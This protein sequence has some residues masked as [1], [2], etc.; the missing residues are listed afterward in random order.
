MRI[1][2]VE[3]DP[4]LLDGLREGLKLGG[5]VADGVTTAADASEALAT[6]NFD[7]VVLDRMLP[8]GSGLDVLNGIRRAGNRVPVL[9]LTAKDEVGDR[10]DGLDA[11]ADDYLGKPFDL[12]EVAARLRAI[13]RRA[14]G[15]ASAQ[16]SLRG[17]TLDPASMQVLREGSAIILSRREFSILHALMANPQAIHSK[18]ALEE[19]LYGWQ[20]D[21]ESNTIEVHVHKLRA[22]L[23]SA[24]I[25][26]VRGVGYRL[27][28]P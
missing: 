2:I 4:I 6:G 26:T 9:L 20:E 24:S 15:R 23:G 11:G 22:K 19:R 28:M 12:D 10:I 13:T 16:I 7:A 21:V 25:E 14:A 27:G 1:L 3:D 8:D 5:F 18:Q 17:L